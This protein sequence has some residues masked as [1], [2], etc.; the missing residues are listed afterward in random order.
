[1]RNDFALGPP[2]PAVR[3]RGAALEWGRSAS[4]WLLAA[5]LVLL[6]L[7]SSAP[8]PLYVVYQAEWGF[9]AIT[10]TSVFGV[11]ALTLLGALVVAGDVSDH[12]GRRPALLLGLG[13][14][15]VA[16]LAFAEAS[17]VGWLFA[18]RALQGLDTGLAMG[19]ISAA[20]LDLQPRHAPRL[21]AL[22]GVA[23]PLC[24]LAVGGLG[25]GALVEYGP[26]PTRLVFWVLSA[27]VG[28]TAALALAVPETVRRRPRWHTALRPRVA[29]PA[30]L[31]GAFAAALPSMAATWALG[32]LILSLGPS[33]TAGVLGQRSHLAAALP[34]FVMAGVSACA[35]VAL[36]DT[37]ARTTARGGLVAVIAGVA[38]VLVALHERSAVLFLAG[39]AIAGLGFGP[40]FGGTFRALGDRA[41]ADAR[42]ALLSAMLAVAYLAFSLPAV[43]AGVAVTQFGLRDTAYVYGA[44][45]IVLASVALALSHRVQDAPTA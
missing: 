6:V 36:R 9:S 44:A 27:L 32:G 24:G 12:V 30:E 5:T 7:A 40:A 11:Y 31:R 17:G 20:L 29:V 42:A 3:R 25:A 38:V 8:S 26:H 39:T 10:L 2:A 4:F 15:L 28:L 35:S 34:I 23:A 33:L 1:V 16:M 14:E 41:P 18:A 13:V 45:L 22:V 37:P 19:A 21:G 43:A